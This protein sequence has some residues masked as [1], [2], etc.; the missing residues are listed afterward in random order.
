[1]NLKFTVYNLL[2]I[3]QQLL[4]PEEKQMCLNPADT[5]FVYLRDVQMVVRKPMSIY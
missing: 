4:L 5:E 2:R 3:F 1:M